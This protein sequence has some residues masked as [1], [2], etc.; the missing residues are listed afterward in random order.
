MTTKKQLLCFAIALAKEIGH[1]GNKDISMDFR[2]ERIVVW[3]YTEDSAESVCIHDFLSL[4]EN[5]K[6]FK[7]A[8]LRIK[9]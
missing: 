8:I 5:K 3:F 9:G 1:S 4:K 6:N 7:K 2:K